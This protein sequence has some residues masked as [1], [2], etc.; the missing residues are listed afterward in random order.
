M[1]IP[2]D[3][4]IPEE[5]RKDLPMIYGPIVDELRRHSARNGFR[6]H[7]HFHHMASSQAAC[8]N[9]FLPILRHSR[10]NE[11]LS[12]LRPDFA[13]LAT[14]QLDQGY[15]IEFWGG[16]FGSDKSDRGPLG[17][18]SAMGGTDSDL[19]IAYRNHA[20]ELCL[21]LIEHKLT[22]A[23]FTPCGGFTSRGRKAHPACKCTRSFA[24]ILAD[25]DICYH[26]HV[27]DRHYWTLTSQSGD[28]FAGHTS[29]AQCPFQGGINQ[30]W[31]NQLLAHAIEQDEEQVFRHASFSVVK[32]ADNVHLD[33]TLKE[34]AELV[35]HHPKFS[36][37][38]SDDV[39][40]A[41]EALRDNALAEWAKWYRTLYN[42]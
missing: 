8:V 40:Q 28:L 32:H 5:M 22:E 39:L 17:D 26:H 42:A 41:A 11:A 37:L 13:S 21:W 14:D 33:K 4:I 20:G 30:L 12:L 2:Y 16:N 24:E 27:L 1:E 25:K 19:A 18:K 36:V 6:L 29:H 9:L 3:A 35:S 23:E 38:T 31:R 34:F 10:V 7:T 15:C